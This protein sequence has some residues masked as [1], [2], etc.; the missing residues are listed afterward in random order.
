M[1]RCLFVGVKGDIMGQKLSG[2][3]G[4]FRFMEGRRIECLPEGESAKSPKSEVS[5]SESSNSSEAQMSQSMEYQS[6]TDESE[7]NPSSEGATKQEN[8]PIPSCQC[9]PS[10]VSTEDAGG[11]GAIGV[12]R[13]R[14]EGVEN[15]SRKNTPRVKTKS[16]KDSSGSSGTRKKR[17]THWASRLNGKLK[18]GGLKS[19]EVEIS[20]PSSSG[21]SCVCTGFRTTE[22]HFLGPGVIFEA[23]NKTAA[24][25]G[26]N[27]RA[28]PSRPRE[29]EAAEAFRNRHRSHVEMLQSAAQAL[30][31]FPIEDCDELARLERAREIEE[32]VDP[33]PGF[34]PRENNNNQIF[35]MLPCILPP[36]P[37]VQMPPGTHFAIPAVT[38]DMSTLTA[39]FQ[40]RLGVPGGTVK[41][42]LSPSSN[43]DDPPPSPGSKV[44][45]QA[46]LLQITA[47]SF[48][49]GK[50]DR[51][52][53]ERLLDRRPEGTF[54]L[55][56]SAQEEHLFSVSFRK[57]D[58]SLHARV[59][60]W[61][62]K[63][64][65]DSHDPGVF[66]SS[67]VTGLVEH[68]KDPA[69]CMFFEPML[70]YPLHR[71]FPFPLQ[72]LC[73]A[74]VCSRT[75]YDAI[76]SLKLPKALKAYLKE[77]HY[78]QR[79]RVRRFDAEH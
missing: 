44:H 34:R 16:S 38:V 17:G 52:E 49:W 32:G 51:Y 43:M 8:G 73:R 11:Y 26:S 61:N 29:S 48:Y 30:I 25:E 36:P 15:R 28:G 75:T 41:V 46:N 13:P 12:I 9:S 37:N 78:K 31:D 66:A 21:D 59:E 40:T 56:D 22:E 20:E 6:S 57:Y 18:G 14:R 68:Y 74:V 64:S 19:G 45:T 42:A 79:V 53:A 69:C 35:H 33:P 77:Y 39:M 23:D 3:R 55:R 58:R 2:L 10:V 65:F 71:S 76:G 4:L 70:T 5:Q 63:F 67:T 50:M 60:Q 62:H 1:S 24:R 72:H 47:C 27:R 7:G 54:L